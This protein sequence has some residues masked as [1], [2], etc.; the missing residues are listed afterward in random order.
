MAAHLCNLNKLLE[1][2]SDSPT[3]LSHITCWLRKIVALEISETIQF[4]IM[5]LYFYSVQI[6]TDSY[7]VSTA[8]AWISCKQVRSR[9]AAMNT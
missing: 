4:E 1:E 7:I 9:G 8:R 3:S 2:L 6:N 5:D